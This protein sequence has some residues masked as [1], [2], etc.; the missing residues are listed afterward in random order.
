MDARVDSTSESP[1][2]GDEQSSIFPD[3][4]DDATIANR[5]RTCPVYDRQQLDPRTDAYPGPNT[6]GQMASSQRVHVQC[7]DQGDLTLDGR[8]GRQDQVA[9][10]RNANSRRARPNSTA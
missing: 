9:G 1:I 6:G 5:E 2:P 7:I 4:V 10:R 8:R 3:L